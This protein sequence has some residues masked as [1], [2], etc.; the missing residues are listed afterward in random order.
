MKLSKFLACGMALLDS[1][2]FWIKDAAATEHSTRATS[3][4]GSSNTA[5]V[6]ALAHASLNTL[7]NASDPDVGISREDVLNVY[8]SNFIVDWDGIPT[9]SVAAW[10]YQCCGRVATTTCEIREY[11]FSCWCMTQSVWIDF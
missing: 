1:L 11:D 3:F 8:P 10:V 6:S 9:T 4:R 7:V 2:P 5:Q